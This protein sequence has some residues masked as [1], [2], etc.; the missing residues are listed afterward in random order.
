[1]SSEEQAK[2]DALVVLKKSEWDELQARLAYLSSQFQLAVQMLIRHQL[3]LERDAKLGMIAQSVNA[4]FENVVADVNVPNNAPLYR[5][6]PV[7]APKVSKILTP[8]VL[9][10]NGRMH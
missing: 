9:P 6:V 10:M 8:G 4:R 1:M 5:F 7:N 2:T 3:T